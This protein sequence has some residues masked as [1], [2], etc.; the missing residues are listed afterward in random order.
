M[1]TRKAIWHRQEI[2]IADY[3][4]SKKDDLLSELMR[5]Y[6]SLEQAASALG[7]PTFDRPDHDVNPDA[8]TNLVQTRVEGKNYFR[9]KMDSW[10]GIAFKYTL[11]DKKNN[12]RREVSE[13]HEFARRFP[14]AFNLIKEFGDDCPIAQYSILAP[15]SSIF[16]HTG[17]ENREGKYIRIHIPLIVPE[18]DVFLEVNGEEVTWEDLFGFNNQYAHSAH[19]L[20]DQWRMIFLI[21]ID[22]I[23]A[24]LEPGSPYD[25]KYRPRPFMR[26]L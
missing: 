3:L 16:R 15:N 8:Y 22:R 1:E 17:P 11:L 18:G 20:T 21:D 9:P 24:G 5:D 12:I 6:N 4:M 25:P 26:K 13:D 10:K 23:R 2:P 19:N 14:T 7:H